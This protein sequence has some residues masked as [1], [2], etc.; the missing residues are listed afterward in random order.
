MSSPSL[1]GGEE[2][3]E[4]GLGGDRSDAPFLRP[5]S[6][7]DLRGVLGDLTSSGSGAG[8]RS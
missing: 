5:G 4:Q 1:S 2:G 8:E 3:G 6:D 7:S